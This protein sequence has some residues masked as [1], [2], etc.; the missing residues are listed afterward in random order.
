VLYSKS[1]TVF[2]VKWYLILLTYHNCQG[3]KDFL[4]RAHFGLPSVEAE[5]DEGRPPIKVKFEIPYFTVSGIQVRFC[6]VPTSRK[7]KISSD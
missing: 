6:G 2:L 4:M 7:F 5:E 1:K 3:G